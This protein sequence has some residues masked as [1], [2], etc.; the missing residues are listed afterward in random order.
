MNKNKTTLKDLLEGDLHYLEKKIEL[1]KKTGNTFSFLEDLIELNK[2]GILT[3]GSQRGENS[4]YVKQK[5]YVEFSCEYNIG[6]KLFSKL[7]GDKNVYFSSTCYAKD[8]PFYFDNLPSEIFN[9]TEY[10]KDDIG[11]MNWKRNNLIKETNIEEPFILSF[12][13]DYLGEDSF[14]YK[15]LLNNIHI[16]IVYKDYSEK[17][18]APKKLLGLLKVMHN[19]A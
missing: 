18:S 9:L 4:F 3:Y 19:D 8:K 10:C 13:K 11:N 5:S 15:E 2:K 7:V 1:K 6:L 17:L 12:Y 14:V 16:F